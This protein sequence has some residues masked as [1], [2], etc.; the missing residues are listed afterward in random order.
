MRSRLMNLSLLCAVGSCGVALAQAPS[1][2][3]PAAKTDQPPT[4]PTNARFAPTYKVYR[5]VEG[6]PVDGSPL[7]KQDNKPLF[8]EQT[9]AP[10]RATAPYKVTTLTNALSAPWSLAFLPDGNILITERLPGALRIL[11]RE[12]V[13]S[14][15]LP[16]LPALASEAQTG[17]LDVALDPDFATNQRIYFTFFGYANR[18]VGQTNVAR[19]RLNNNTLTDVTVIF[20]SLP[21]MPNG[22]NLAAGTKT[23]GRIAVD[24]DGTLFVA[25]GDRDAGGPNPWDV[26]QK[27]DSHLG[28]IIHITPEGKPAAGNPFIGTP[29]ALPEIWATGQRSQEG[30]AFDPATHRLWE[31][32]HGPRG[33]D[34]LNL[35]VKGK[36]YGWP[37]I[38]HGID[39]AGAPIGAG[40]AAKEG[41]EQPV[42]Y[43][44]PVIAASGLAFYQ[45]NLFPEWKNSVFV[46]GLA[47]TVLDRLT[48][49]EGKVVAEEA[50]LSDLQER[51]RDVRVGPDGAVYVLTDSGTSVIQDNTPPTSKL[52]KLTPK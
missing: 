32:E 51:I 14:K 35:I 28:K 5:T 50:L 47:G 36:N 31:T 43:W 9:R 1:A 39:Y 48:L 27:L 7:E 44:D 2:T 23:G 52:L 13:L 22:S 26:A 33:G 15:P 45:G 34:E 18:V 17:L 16:G 30:L 6:Q 29:G 11:N 10:Y 24:R 46:G 4:R 19:A 21:S 8:P 25:I 49:R 37:V 41:M 3:P 38:S 42:Y 40:I 12:G 20:R